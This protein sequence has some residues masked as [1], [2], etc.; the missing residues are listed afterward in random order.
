MKIKSLL[1][2]LF[3][4]IVC[5]GLA[6]CAALQKKPQQVSTVKK[7]ANK[8]DN[9]TRLR[10]DIAD[11]A[12][13]QIG[14]RYVHAGKNNKGFDC[15]G[16]VFFVMNKYG[17][18]VPGSSRTQETYGKQ[19]SPANTKSGDLIFFRRSKKGEVFHVAIVYANDENGLQV[20]HSTSS[21]G[22]VLDNISNNSYWSPK[23]STGR[24]VIS[25]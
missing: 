14:T 13:Q 11:Y 19:I 4:T 21:R 12:H 3:F 20:V 17:I 7:S 18:S 8:A 2:L 16:F 25:D 6:R 22:V 1:P 10:N 23:I 24:D 15:S 5:F 9:K